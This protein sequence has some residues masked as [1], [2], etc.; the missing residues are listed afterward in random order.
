LRGRRLGRCFCH[1][2][3]GH[4][5]RRHLNWFF[6]HRFFDGLGLLS[7]NRFLGRNDDWFRRFDQT[8]RRQHRC[9]PLWRLGRLL[10]RHPLL[11]FERWRLGE[12]VAARKRDVPLT[13]EAV[14]KLAGDDF[15]DR[16]RGALDLDAMIA[17]QQRSD[18]LAG[19]AQEFCD[20]VNPDCGQR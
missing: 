11:A 4:C 1:G 7:G 3:F 20:L 14:H 5:D 13:S 6:D 9:D 8:G 17:L 18:F 19:R 2:R 15:L 16:A 10:C 12:N